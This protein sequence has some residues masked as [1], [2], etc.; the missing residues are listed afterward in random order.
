MFAVSRMLAGCATFRRDGGDVKASRVGIENVAK[1]ALR[2][3]R[4]PAVLLSRLDA[5]PA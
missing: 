5:R 2:L 4:L 1:Q 3:G